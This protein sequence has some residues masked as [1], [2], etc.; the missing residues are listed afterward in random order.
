MFDVSSKTIVDKKFR[1]AELYRLI[2][3]DKDVKANV[4]NILSITLS[5]VLSNDTLNLSEQG[6][7][8]EIY[9]FDIV[10]SDKTIPTLFIAA[11]DKAINLHTIFILHNDDKSMLYGAYKE[12]TERG[13]KVG[14]YY[15]TEWKVATEKIPL[16]LNVVRIDDIYTAIID[17]LIPFEAKEDESTEEFVARYEEIKKMQKEIDRLQ[18]LVD[19]E[20]QPKKRF[21]L[22]D[23]LKRKQRELKALTD[24]GVE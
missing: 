3:A 2:S 12:Q 21:E 6:K 1:L 13:V 15:S 19:S 5:N 8:K 9:I 4:K 22:N 11:L 14:K 24:K 7:V 23:E 16:P 20:R 10:L 18:R 17:L